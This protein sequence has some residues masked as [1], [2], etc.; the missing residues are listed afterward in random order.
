MA[1]INYIEPIKY[2]VRDDGKLIQ[3][4]S[5]PRGMLHI[6][7]QYQEEAD[8]RVVSFIDHGLELFLSREE[9]DRGR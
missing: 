2:T 3:E 7:L 1:Q 5:V 8:K 9:G 6:V 4:N